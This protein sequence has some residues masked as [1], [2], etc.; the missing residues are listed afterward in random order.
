MWWLAF[1]LLFLLFLL[2]AA[3]VA[4]QYLT[5]QP[6][7]NT[8][9]CA[10]GQCAIDIY[11]GVKTCPT[12]AQDVVRRDITSQ[13]CGPALGCD[14]N[15]KAP[16]V[17]DDPTKGT[18]CPG[19]KD[20]PQLSTKATKCT[21]RR[22]CPDFATVYFDIYDVN[23]FNAPSCG[24]FE[25]LVQETIWRDA[26]NLPRNDLPL[27]LGPVGLSIA[28]CGITQQQRRLMW[29]SQTCLR[30][31]LAKN[32]EDQLFYCM[33]VPE[34]TTCSARQIPERQSDGSFLC[35]TDS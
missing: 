6:P 4:W 30:G 19:D 28:V 27:Q 15:S 23:T 3:W 31:K 33:N 1:L 24:Q 8:Q 18:I 21:G 17:F 12:D 26:T 10:K 14:P 32:K 9:P 5:Q 22:Y 2:V 35:V 34:E 11:T 25:A 29:P 7:E 20:Y 13:V 16:C